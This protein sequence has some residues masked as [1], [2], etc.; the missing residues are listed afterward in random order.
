LSCHN[1]TIFSPLITTA[2]GATQGL[3]VPI[4]AILETEYGPVFEPNDVTILVT[5]FE[6]AL[7]KLRLGDRDD[8]MTV[9]VAKL[10]IQLAKDG[11][12]DPQK[13]CDGAL[14]ILRSSA[15]SE[16]G[17][18]G[19]LRRVVNLAD[20][21]GNGLVSTL[22]GGGGNI[23]GFTAF[24]FKTAGKWL[25]LL[26]EIAPGVKR[27]AFVFGGADFGS[28]GEGFYGVIARRPRRTESN[29]CPSASVPAP[30]RP[31][32]RLP[33]ANSQPRAAAA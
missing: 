27:A 30:P 4:R 31:T 11:E 2:Y 17:G 5:A 16:A 12:R 6:A 14:K 28:T 13:L 1:Q 22:K 21:V 20:P 18:G 15:V 10:I 33:S 23:T 7:A 3:D 29:S 26:A 9:T 8:A 25:E 32:S 24:E 19:R